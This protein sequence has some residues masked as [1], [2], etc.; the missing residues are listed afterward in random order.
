MS[1]PLRT[2]KEDS[3]SVD[4]RDAGALP[5]ASDEEDGKVLRDPDIL[6]EAP[7]IDT[8]RAEPPPRRLRK[9][10]VVCALLYCVM[11]VL[12]L[13][14]MA[15]A[16]SFYGPRCNLSGVKALVM[17]NLTTANDVFL[18]TTLAYDALRNALAEC[19]QS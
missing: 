17:V 5:P 13:T 1:E 19:A 9:G 6:S 16:A 2:V 3:S 14:A 10:F 7:D 12:I 18:H 4:L 8:T 11:N 15:I